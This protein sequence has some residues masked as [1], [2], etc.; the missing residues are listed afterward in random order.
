LLA[1]SVGS[2]AKGISLGNP[3][4]SGSSTHFSYLLFGMIV[5]PN[6]YY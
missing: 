5:V 2:S 4:Q 3:L 6:D 1:F